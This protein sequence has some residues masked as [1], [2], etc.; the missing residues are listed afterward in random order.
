VLLANVVGAFGAAATFA[1]TAAIPP[2]VLPAIEELS[3]QATG[4]PPFE[5]F[6]R[7]IPAGVLVAAIVWMLPQSAGFEFFLIL[8]FTWVIAAGVFMHIVAGSVEMAFLLLQGLLSPA[9][10]LFGFFL[11]VLAGNVLGGTLIFALLAFGQVR[12]E[13]VKQ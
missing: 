7:A 9:D 10:A 12:R 5:A 11:P 8:T 2:E 1:F 3:R 4:L 13:L 6:Q